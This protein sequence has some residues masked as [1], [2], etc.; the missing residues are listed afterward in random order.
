MANAAASLEIEQETDSFKQ[1]AEIIEEYV[2]VLETDEETLSV[3][4]MS[5]RRS[6][7]SSLE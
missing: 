3:L 2:T 1:D 4:K 7:W 6:N 5:Q